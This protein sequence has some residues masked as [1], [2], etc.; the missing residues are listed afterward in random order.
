MTVFIILILLVIT[1][2]KEYLG[3]WLERSKICAS[4][5]GYCLRAVLLLDLRRKVLITK[6]AEPDYGL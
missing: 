6:N 2:K 1:K 4:E 5:L 3:N